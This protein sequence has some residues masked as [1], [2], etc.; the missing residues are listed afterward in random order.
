[1]EVGRG[2]AVVKMRGVLVGPAVSVARLV[3]VV[4]A[5]GVKFGFSVDVGRAVAVT[6]SSSFADVQLLENVMI[7]TNERLSQILVF[8]DTRSRTELSVEILSSN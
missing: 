6:D 2:V 5:G 8:I 7:N 4:R 3:A 1:M